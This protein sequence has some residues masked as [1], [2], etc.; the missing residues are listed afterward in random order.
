M[1]KRRGPSKKSPR[2]ASAL[3]ARIRIP[4]PPPNRKT[5]RQQIQDYAQA[6]GG[7]DVTALDKLTAFQAS[8]PPPPKMTPERLE[9]LR[10]ADY[11]GAIERSGNVRTRDIQK[12][13]DADPGK[14]YFLTMRLH[15]YPVSDDEGKPAGYTDSRTVVFKGLGS[16][17]IKKVHYFAVVLNA[18]IIKL[19]L[20][21]VDESRLS[22][23]PRFPTAKIRPIFA[24]EKVPLA[25]GTEK[26]GAGVRFARP[27]KRGPK[28]QSV[29]VS[30]RKWTAAEK[31]KLERANKSKTRYWQLRDRKGK[32]AAD[33]FWRK[34]SAGRKS[35]KKKGR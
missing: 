2:A 30:K 15:H 13:K 11:I 31:K 14:Y 1:A 7:I 3:F 23:D 32:K 24:D 25:D 28:K 35:H 17:C 8:I 34:V 16:L 12:L 19:T 4:T 26:F 20:D 6:R 29:T 21:L 10:A 22:T 18:T 33:S 9:E 27:K 5:L